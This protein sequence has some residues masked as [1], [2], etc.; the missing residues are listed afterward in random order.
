M[1]KVQKFTEVLISNLKLTG[2]LMRLT[3]RLF[4]SE[5]MISLANDGKKG[6]KAKG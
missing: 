1:N 4:V 6:L 2:F 5:F 3:Y